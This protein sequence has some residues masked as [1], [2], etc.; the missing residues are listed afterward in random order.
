MPCIT[1]L[2]ILL[3]LLQFVTG[4]NPLNLATGQ[5][6]TNYFPALSS[7]QE[8]SGSGYSADS[9]YACYP[10]Q[11]LGPDCCPWSFG[12]G[13]TY[14][15]TF[16]WTQTTSGIRRLFQT[17]Q[18]SLWNCVAGC[19]TVGS[20]TAT[21]NAIFTGPANPITD[22]AGCP[23]TCASGY[24]VNGTAC[25]PCPVGTYSDSPGATVCKNC[26]TSSSCSNGYYLS[27]CGGS[28]AGSCVRCT[29]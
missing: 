22:P 21:A 20:C 12:Q 28:S 10:G 6:C 25:A 9:K 5:Y 1:L 13:C 14:A 19:V 8:F 11:G 4:Q 7:C 2:P 26:P 16:T 24:F 3:V 27:G 29:N 18:G 15:G 17:H 23:F